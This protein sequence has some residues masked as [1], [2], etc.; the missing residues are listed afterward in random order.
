MISEAETG[1][2]VAGYFE[3]MLKRQFEAGD[4]SVL[5]YAIYACLESRRPIPEWLRVAFLD[6]YEA[7][8]RFESDHGM[9]YLANQFPRART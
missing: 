1:K 5:L 9:K 7:A 3:K 8:E 2:Y 4:K 6:A